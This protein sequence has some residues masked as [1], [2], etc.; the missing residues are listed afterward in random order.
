MNGTAL[1]KKSSIFTGKK[2]LIYFIMGNEKKDSLY[3]RFNI[4]LRN[5][6]YAGTLVTLFFI[7]AQVFFAKRAMTES[8]EW[9]KAKMTIENIER[10]KKNLPEIKLYE[11]EV[12][13]LGDGEWPDFSTVEG[14]KLADTLQKAYSS[15]FSNDIER[16]NDLL[17]TS[18]I[19][20]AF[21]YP[22]IMGYASEIGSFQS[23]AIDYY[24]L[25][26]FIM[27]EIYNFNYA[28]GHH[29]KLLY[30]LWRIRSE[31]LFL[32]EKID[33]NNISA[34]ELEKMNKPEDIAR[35]LCFDDTEVTIETLKPYKKKLMKELKKVQKEIEV[36]RK[37]SL[38]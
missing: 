36:F 15:L 9:E 30:R 38:K 22:I 12:L 11:S 29:A 19:L 23:V 8:S 37:N 3:Y 14:R 26:N 6:Y 5:L 28:I 20:D 35:M 25:S 13:R 32:F 31:H 24:R 10:F 34:E 27:P 7:M 33:I 2:K 1:S 16:V 17:K 4:G 18:D 21:A